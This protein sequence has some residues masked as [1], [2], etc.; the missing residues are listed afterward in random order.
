M[1]CD[2]AIV[3]FVKGL[4]G[5]SRPHLAH[6]SPPDAPQTRWLCRKLADVV[7]ESHRAPGS[8]P[9]FVNHLVDLDP[10]MW[11]PSYSTSQL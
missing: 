1:E 2:V 3:A 5:P 6:I 7:D 8:G 10:L 11:L 9:P 4:V